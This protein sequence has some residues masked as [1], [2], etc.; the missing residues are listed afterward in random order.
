MLDG[1]VVVDCEVVRYT[2]N[3]IHAQNVEFVNITYFLTAILVTI[4][5]KRINYFEDFVIEGN[6]TSSVV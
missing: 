6:S 2:S 5:F 1:K 4:G 3:R